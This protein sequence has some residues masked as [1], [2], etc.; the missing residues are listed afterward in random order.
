MS[1]TPPTTAASSDVLAVALTTAFGP[2]G[3]LAALAFKFGSPFVAK[4]IANAHANADPTVAEWAALDA[5]ID[6]PGEVLI[7]QRPTAPAV[8]AA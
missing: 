2:W 7:P 1:A 4:L 8:K 3:A 5:E 6:T